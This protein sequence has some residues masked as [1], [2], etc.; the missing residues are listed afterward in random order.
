MLSCLSGPLKNV[1]SLS[2]SSCP[3]GPCRLGDHVGTSMESQACR[4]TPGCW[5][6]WGV[7]GAAL[8]PVSTASWST[9]LKTVLSV[10]VWVALLATLLTM[11]ETEPC[12]GWGTGTMLREHW[13][14]LSHSHFLPAPVI[15]Q[16]HWTLRQSTSWTLCLILRECHA[17]ACGSSPRRMAQRTAQLELPRSAQA[18]WLP[19][20]TGL[21]GRSSTISC[22]LLSGHEAGHTLSAASS[23]FFLAVTCG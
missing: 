14:L 4:P 21:S 19:S 1:L 10:A 12:V 6:V 8:S 7:G 22:S 3:R 9:W 17:G 23:C 18:V 5:A 16:K 11:G 20:R 13:R 15:L 2:V